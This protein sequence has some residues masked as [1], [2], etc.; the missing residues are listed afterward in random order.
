MTKRIENIFEQ[1]EK[2]E[3]IISY[4]KKEYKEKTGDDINIINL[5]SKIKEK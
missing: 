3:K 4:L 2:D 5:M 1:L